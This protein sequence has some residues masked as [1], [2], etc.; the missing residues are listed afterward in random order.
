ML[1]AQ[2]NASTPRGRNREL[3]SGFELERSR[4]W[5]SQFDL[6]EAIVWKDAGEKEALLERQDP[7]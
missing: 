5:W 4:I 1:V 2:F 6:G 7:N 3:N